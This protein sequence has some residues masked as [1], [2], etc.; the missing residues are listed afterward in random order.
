MAQ[1]IQIKRGLETNRSGITPLSGEMIW[2]TD[3][4]DM[5]VG[6]GT[7]AGGIKVTANIEANYIPNT[8]K[9]AVNGVAT[10]DAGGHIPNTQLPPLALTEVFTAV[11]ETGQLALTAQEGDVCVRTD[12]N[13]SYIHN[14]GSAGD[15]T[16]WQELLTP[17]DSVTS[18]NGEVGVVSLDTD[19]IN[20]GS[21]NLYFTDGRADTRINAASINALADVDTTTV[22]PVTDDY[23]KFDGTNWVAEAPQTVAI[24]DL[25]DVDTTTTAPTNDQVLKW[26][27][28][29]WVPGDD[30]SSVALLDDIGD[31]NVTGATN[32]QILSWDNAGSEWVAVDPG[33]VTA[34]TLVALSDTPTDYTGAAN[35]FVKVNTGADAVEFTTVGVDELSDVDTTTSAPTSGQVLAWDGTSSWVPATNAD[36]TYTAGTGLDLTGTVFSLDSGI[37]G[38]TDVDTTTVAP[39]TGDI[40][41][42]NGTNWV[43]GANVDGGTF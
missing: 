30:T 27:G 42:W 34:T 18:V 33:A 24:D 8:A 32:N 16:D 11:D 29:N 23:L 40:M 3:N 9:G 19:D 39:S 36:T 12:E 1:N 15:M 2:T 38:L 22:A 7:T 14:G 31:V 37:D 41:G 21:T 17:T 10:L 6:N 28:T 25:S 4:N 26:D 20:E 43:P 5:W 13:K 35:Q